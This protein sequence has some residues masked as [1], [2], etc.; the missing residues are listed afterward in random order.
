MGRSDQLLFYLAHWDISQPLFAHSCSMSLCAYRNMQ[1]CPRQS[2]S[3]KK[4]GE[5]QDRECTHPP[6]LFTRLL[7]RTDG[8]I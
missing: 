5:S 1:S 8:L 4:R 3:H 2:F 6:A 7:Q